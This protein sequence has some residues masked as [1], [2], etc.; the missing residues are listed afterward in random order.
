MKPFY[1]SNYEVI[2]IGLQFFILVLIA[3]TITSYFNYSKSVISIVSISIASVCYLLSTIW[4]KKVM[5]FTNKVIVYYPTKI[6]GEKSQTYLL[7]DIVKVTYYEYLYN[8]P[9]H[10][11]IKTKHHSIKFDCDTND[12]ILILKKYNEIGVEIES[13][14]NNGM[15]MEAFKKEINKS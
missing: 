9:S 8:I 14:P 7:K 13:I 1:E 10:V 12:G 3:L 2:K 4:I 6:F 15:F 11:K 5:T